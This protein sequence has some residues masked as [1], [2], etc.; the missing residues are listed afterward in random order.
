VGAP[1]PTTIRLAGPRL[2]TGRIIAQDTRQPLS[3]A[4]VAIVVGVDRNMLNYYTEL[5]NAADGLPTVPSV[6]LIAQADA[7]G[8]Y[9]MRLPVATTYQMICYPPNGSAHVGTRSHFTWTDGQTTLERN[10]ILPP[11][12]EVQGMV[13]EEDGR[14]IAGASPTNP[15]RIRTSS[16]QNRYLSDTA[17]LS[18][19][20]GRFRLIVPTR[21]TILSVIGPTADYQLDNY[22]YQRCPQCGKD[23]LR[24]VEHARIPLDHSTPSWLRSVRVTLRRG[25]PVEGRAVGPDGEPIRQGIV[26][27][28]TIA[29]PLRQSMPRNLPIRDGVFRLPG[30]I[31]GRVYP[32]LLLDAENGLAT[33]TE[34]RLP[35]ESEPPL[36]VR[37]AKCG[38]AAMRLVDDAGKPLAGERM[39]L[40][41]WLPDDRSAELDA[42]DSAPLSTAVESAWI[43]P[44]HFLPGPATDQDGRLNLPGIIP[45]LKYTAQYAAPGKRTANTKPFR[46]TPGQALQLQELQIRSGADDARQENAD[47][48]RQF[49]VIENPA[50]K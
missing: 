22:E 31:P 45:G 12:V 35:Y 40:Y 9:R 15:P 24:T 23:H 38:S 10:A 29:H 3:G 50:R 20:D 36:I 30:C 13:V 5:V 37:L 11:G 49:K 39:M 16:Q 44:R 7:E 6:E 32:V 34:L 17:R 46:L 8:R 33:T 41:F 18:G 48:Q 25:Q 47:P 28:R 43:D 19:P 42:E 2:L 4:R 21:P 14:P 27:C 1:E 26:V